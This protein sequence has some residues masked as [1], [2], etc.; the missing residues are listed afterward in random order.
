M[1]AAATVSKPR[2][3]CNICFKTF[4]R[5]EHLTRHSSVHV[6]TPQ[7]ICVTCNK[8]FRRSDALHR[9][10][11]IHQQAQ[12]LPVKGLRACVPCV[13]A[14][15][16]CDGCVPCARCLKRAFQCQSASTSQQGPTIAETLLGT[17]FEVSPGERL[18]KLAQATKEVPNVMQVQRPRPG[19]RVP[20]EVHD[21][22]GAQFGSF[23]HVLHG[24]GTGSNSTA[25]VQ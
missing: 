2:H 9:H 25:T 8:N 5:P 15:T 21:D 7:H 18:P 6:E 17:D 11:L 13:K 3:E 14:K 22:T 16:K 12:T 19:S 23:S 24:H 1:E 20:V 10:E 4:A